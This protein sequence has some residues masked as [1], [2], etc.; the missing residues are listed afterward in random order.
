M[1]GYYK[2]KADGGLKISSSAGNSTWGQVDGTVTHWSMSPR[3][4]TSTLTTSNGVST[5]IDF[6]RSS[7]TTALL[8]TTG[9]AEGESVKLGD[10]TL[11]I[12]F[13]G[14]GAH[15]T[16]IVQADRV[17]AGKQAISLK[18]GNLIFHVTEVE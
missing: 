4:Q 9:R 10:K 1:G 6:T 13:L 17:V 11:T 14:E 5:G 15:P 3:G 18:D 2:A 7:G 12:A 8:V 16:A